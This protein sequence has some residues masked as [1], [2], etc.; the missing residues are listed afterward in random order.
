VSSEARGCSGI[1]IIA[2][3]LF[4]LFMVLG[5]VLSQM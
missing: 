1:V 4:I 3:G 2:A 5:L